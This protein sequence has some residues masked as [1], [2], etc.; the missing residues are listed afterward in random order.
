[1][2]TTGERAENLAPRPLPD[3]STALPVHAHTEPDHSVPT[4]QLI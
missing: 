4:G 1:M 3:L 2:L